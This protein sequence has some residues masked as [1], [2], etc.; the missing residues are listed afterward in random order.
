MPPSDRPKFKNQRFKRFKVKSKK[1]NKTFMLGTD[2]DGNIGNLPYG[3][4]IYIRA[5]LLAST[6]NGTVLWY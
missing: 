2:E 1:F 5:V 3:G 6:R 4:G